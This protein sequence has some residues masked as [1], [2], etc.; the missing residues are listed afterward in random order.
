MNLFTRQEQ[1]HRYQ[2]QTYGHLG[3]P[4]GLDGKESAWN[5][6]RHRFDP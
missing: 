5:T 4:G 3:F 1:T 2:K 6:R